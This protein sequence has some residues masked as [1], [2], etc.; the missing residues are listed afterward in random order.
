[1]KDLPDSGK[2]AFG[3]E[4]HR[5][6]LVG[7]C[8][9]MLGSIAEADDAVQETMV[10]AWRAMDRFEGRASPRTWLYSIATRVCLDA[11]AKSGRRARPMELG[12]AYSIDGPL[13]PLPADSWIEPIPDV[14]AVPTDA[15]PAERLALRQSIRLAFL[16]ALQ[17]LPPKQRAVLLLAEVLGWAAT[18]IAETLET[19]VASVNSALQRARATVADLGLEDTDFQSPASDA[20]AALLNRYVDAFERYDMD[21]FTALL[22][23]EVTLSMPPLTLWLQGHESIRGWF[24][25][26]GAVCRG[27]RLVPTS[28]CGSPAFGQYHDDGSGGPL[29]PWSLIVLEV[30]GGRIAAMTHFLDAKTLF[31]R[32]GLPMELPR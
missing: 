5:T 3:F 28:A 15:D 13:T 23:E 24:L 31:P 16:A 12:P 21:A 14:L 6:A 27:S 26:R 20:Q 11:L 17:H 7:H 29:H 8:Y 25:G 30:S 22:H 32:F 10:R 18:E 1:M 9:R 2:L 19:S 4:E